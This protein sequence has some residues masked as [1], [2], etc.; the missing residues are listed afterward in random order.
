MAKAKPTPES[1]PAPSPT[2]SP[3]IQ[4]GFRADEREK[5]DSLLTIRDNA[6]ARLETAKRAFADAT[7]DL[8]ETQ[9]VK[10]AK[11]RLVYA[12]KE[13]YVFLGR[14]R[15]PQDTPLFPNESAG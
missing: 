11:E 15:K 14:V 10:D 1:D 13:L 2:P 6:V 8:D 5:L 12:Q 4:V 7:K 3:A 9:D